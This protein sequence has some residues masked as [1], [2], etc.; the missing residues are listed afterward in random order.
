MTCIMGKSGSG[1]STLLNALSGITNINNGE[2]L[3]NNTFFSK[4]SN[5]EKC[6]FRRE[7]IGI[8]FQF[9]NLIPELSVYENIV[10][11]VHLNHDEVDMLFLNKL[12]DTLQIA[13]LI[14][15]F[16]NNLSGGEQQRVAIARALIKK[17]SIVLADEPTGNLDRQ[18]SI[19]V[20]QLLKEC[21]L[22]YRQNIII[23]THDFDVA[24][25][26]DRILYLEDGKVI[27]DEKI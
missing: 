18:N 16:P 25:Q 10:L 17:P 19:H 11:P 7:N 4:L 9:Y 27:Q 2:I 21:Q 14:D 8:I 3:I 26:C 1:K 24:K 6:N 15:K 23:V 12:L 5:N 13:D 22:L 20:I